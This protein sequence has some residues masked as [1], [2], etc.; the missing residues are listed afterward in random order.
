M[1][2]YQISFTPMAVFHV[3]L[4]YFGDSSYKI[5]H[6]E[7]CAFWQIILLFAFQIL[8]MRSSEILRDS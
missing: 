3:E 8:Q 2:Q 1:N 5:W 7:L 6:E 4:Y